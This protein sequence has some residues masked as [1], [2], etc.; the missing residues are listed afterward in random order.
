M[1][2]SAYRAYFSEIAPHLVPDLLPSEITSHPQL[3]AV[4]VGRAERTRW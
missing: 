2:A 1:S 4:F 3:L